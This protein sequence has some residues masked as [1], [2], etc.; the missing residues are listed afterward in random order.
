MFYLCHLNI[1]YKSCRNVLFIIVN[2]IKLF[3]VSSYWTAVRRL[4][5]WDVNFYL[6][7]ISG[8]ST[9]Y[10]RRR[11][12]QAKFVVSYVR[13]VSL[14]YVVQTIYKLGNTDFWKLFDFWISDSYSKS[15]LGL[16]SVNTISFYLRDKTL[17]YLFSSKIHETRISK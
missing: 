3:S 15:K 9:R 1:L 12:Y 4:D 2:N 10:R 17:L 6:F 13:H 11:E 5:S 16:Y 8:V 7:V 14:V